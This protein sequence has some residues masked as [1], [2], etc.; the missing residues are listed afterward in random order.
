MTS[1]E[2]ILLAIAESAEAFLRDQR[3]T[4]DVDEFLRRLGMAADVDRAYLFRVEY[5]SSWATHSLCREWCSPRAIPQSDNPALQNLSFCGMGEVLATLEAGMPWRVDDISRL[6]PGVIRGILAPQGILSL[7]LVP[8][9]AHGG[10]WGY[11]GLD[12]C[13]SPREWTGVELAAL[14]TGASLLGAA[15]DRELRDR[16][17]DMAV[18]VLE[19]V[20]ERLEHAT[21]KSRARINE[22]IEQIR[23]VGRGEPDGGADQQPP[24]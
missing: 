19:A 22:A 2:T 4:E 7:V 13:S 5:A 16:D 20:V 14:R 3:G 12:D 10:L 24:G 18:G 1:P 15:F 11:L 9:V 6:P 8:V 21:A 23:R 17:R